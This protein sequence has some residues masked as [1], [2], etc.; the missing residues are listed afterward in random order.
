MDELI[1][2]DKRADG[3]FLEFETDVLSTFTF[4]ANDLRPERTGIHGQLKIDLDGINLAYT[5][6]NIQRNEE[7]KRLVN[8]AYK[9]LGS[10]A[11]DAELIIDKGKLLKKFNDF[12]LN[13]YPTYLSMNA[14]TEV[15]G[16]QIPVSY[17]LEPHILQGGGTIMF[18]K[19]G[20]G[21]SYTGIV[22]AMA[23]KY[24]L[25]HYWG[26]D[27]G[28]TLY[29]NLERPERTIPPRIYAVGRALG[30][31]S[32][33]LDVQH[34][35]TLMDVKDT[36]Y[37]YIKERDVKFVVIDSISRA[38]TGDMKED[39]VA[40]ATIDMM[41]RFNVSWLA[42]AHTPKYDDST[43]YGSSQYEAGAD[44]M[45]RHGSDIVDGAGSI[46]VLLDVTKANDMPHPDPMGLHYSFDSSGIS[47]IRT[48]HREETAALMDIERHLYRLIKEEML[49]ST[50]GKTVSELSEFFSLQGAKIVEQ[51]RIM[52]HNNEIISMGIR[53]NERIYGI[54][55]HS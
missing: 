21:K 11:A 52:K 37:E 49:R 46:A 50:S 39:R 14:P 13:A 1:K 44:V 55:N 45:L 15:Q 41:K 16:E 36:I 9:Y 12:C 29:V 28:N 2:V 38:G 8:E 40:T 54:E 18:G 24:G 35:T 48:A 32:S 22:M 7:R 31:N 51:I 25:N 33:S 27:Q 34:G 6:C 26:T 19:P 3:V 23:V 4:S 53:D 17:L 47:A 42:V 30:L 10:S 20:T 5:V 43:Y